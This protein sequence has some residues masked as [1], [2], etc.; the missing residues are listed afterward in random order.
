MGSRLS[1]LHVVLVHLPMQGFESLIA[2][3]YFQASMS[4]LETDHK[5]RV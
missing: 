5:F 3:D 2:A 1:G 4:N